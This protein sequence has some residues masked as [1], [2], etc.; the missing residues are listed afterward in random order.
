MA[1]K[2]FIS[3]LGTGLYKDCKYARGNFISNDV[4]FIQEVTLDYIGARDWTSN[5]A[6]YILL[7]SAAREKNWENDG[8]KKCGTQETIKQ[9]GL[10]ERLKAM[11][12]SAKVN[13]ISVTDGNDEMKI[14]SLFMTMYD[15]LEVDDE[16]YLDITHAFRYLPM[17]MV[18]LGNYAKFLKNVTIKS[19]TYGNWEGRDQATDIAPIEDLTIYSTLLD[20]TAATA[21]F[22]TSGSAKRLQQLGE[23]NLKPI[24][25]P[26]LK[27][28]RG[29]DKATSALNSFTSKLDDVVNDF[30]L[31]R[32]IP[33]TQ[34]RTI[35]LLRDNI[36][37][38]IDSTVNTPLKPIIELI[39]NEFDP[40]GKDDILNGMRAA[41]WCLD[42][43]MYQQAATMMQE[44]IVSIVCNEAAIDIDNES[45][46]QLVNM[47]F[48]FAKESTP[49]SDWKCVDEDN[50]STV[51]TLLDN[52]YIKNPDLQDIFS[53]LADVRNSINH[54]GMRQNKES[55]DKLVNNIVALLGR[56]EQILGKGDE[57][58]QELMKV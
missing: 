37:E 27:E 21:D 44:T 8:Q 29:S 3:F 54:F 13:D 58:E 39:G 28:L 36:K 10:G 4:R 51:R 33:I 7:T 41:R 57:L 15:L 18:V 52:K 17:L 23:S 34:G 56:I 19:I 31:C 14:M 32:G 45:Q 47:A 11:Q 5:D 43:G 48:K 20:W 55:A 16:L 30:K 53:F 6:I 46:R 42:R 22:L 26:I 40:Y 25:R 2:V 1:R 50:L 9:I 38:A 49:E 12:L 24:L 35:R